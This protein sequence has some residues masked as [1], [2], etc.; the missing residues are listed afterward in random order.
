[1]LCNG[2]TFNISTYPELYQV[3]GTNVLP[4]LRSQFIRGSNTSVAGQSI[5]QSSTPIGQHSHYYDKYTQLMTFTADKI[6]APLDEIRTYVSNISSAYVP[7]LTSFA[8]DNTSQFYP[9]HM[10]VH[11]IIKAKSTRAFRNSIQND[12]LP[13]ASLIANIDRLLSNIKLDM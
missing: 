8:G 10:T 13:T 5:S 4:D 2:S 6:Y 3:L 1:M 7:T 12:S 9:A 11:F